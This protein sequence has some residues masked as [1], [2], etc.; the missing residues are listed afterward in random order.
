M[1][2]GTEKH[3]LRVWLVLLGL[4][5]A[6][7]LAVGFAGSLVG[8]GFVLSLAMLKARLVVLDFM[9]LRHSK[10]VGRAL[11]GWCAILAVLAVA[12]VAIIQ[13]AVG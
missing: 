11:V 3:L 1:G 12:K 5:S 9:G 2:S 8:L 7:A 13:L 10:T 4:T 6:S